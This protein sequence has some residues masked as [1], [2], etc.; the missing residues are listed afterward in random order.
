MF[1]TTLSIALKRIRY[2]FGD[3]K[4]KSFYRRQ[5]PDYLIVLDTP[6]GRRLSTQASVSSGEAWMKVIAN[7]SSLGYSNS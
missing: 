1:T 2:G 6:E 5:I 7:P 4:A 3:A